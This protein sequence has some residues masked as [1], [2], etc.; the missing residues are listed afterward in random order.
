MPT[1][2]RR[3]VVENRISCR[4]LGSYA[5]DIDHYDPQVKKSPLTTAGWGILQDALLLIIIAGIVCGVI[6]WE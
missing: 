3:G 4:R 2:Q 6:T 1:G 5:T